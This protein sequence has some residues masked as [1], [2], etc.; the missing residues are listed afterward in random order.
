MTLS[1]ADVLYAIATAANG[2]QDMRNSGRPLDPELVQSRGIVNFY[3]GDAP[4]QGFY[5]A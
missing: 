5:A 3:N 1:K 2:Q 4:L